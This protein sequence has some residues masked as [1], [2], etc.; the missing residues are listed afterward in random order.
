MTLSTVDTGGTLSN[1]SSSRFVQSHSVGKMGEVN[2]IAKVE[3]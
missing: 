1:G 3:W 2:F